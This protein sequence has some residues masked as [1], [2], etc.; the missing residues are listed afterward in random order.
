[1]IRTKFC[2]KMCLMLL[3]T[4]AV[5]V[6]DIPQDPLNFTDIALSDVNEFSL[7]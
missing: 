2:L 4:S 6:T 1:M 7:V 5:G 3:I